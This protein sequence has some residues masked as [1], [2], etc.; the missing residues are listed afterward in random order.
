MDETIVINNSSNVKFPDYFPCVPCTFFA[1]CQ[2]HADFC[3]RCYKRRFIAYWPVVLHVVCFSR[4]Y[5]SVDYRWCRFKDHLT[6]TSNGPCQNWPQR[7]PPR[8]SGHI[9]PLS[10]PSV[11]WTTSCCARTA[12]DNKNLAAILGGSLRLIT[13]HTGSFRSPDY[14]INA[15]GIPRV[16]QTKTP[17]GDNHTSSASQGMRHCL[18]IYLAGL[19]LHLCPANERRRY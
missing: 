4:Q 11:S 5:F 13:H 16:Y 19:I 12:D 6:P 17:M 3:R 15:P 7:H 14:W 2:G 9:S 10:A 1:R 8:D 18:L